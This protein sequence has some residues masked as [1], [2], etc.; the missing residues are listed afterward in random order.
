MRTSLLISAAVGLLIGGGIFFAIDGEASIAPQKKAEISVL[1]CAKPVEGL[2]EYK[3]YTCPV[4]GEEFEVL[5][6]VGDQP[7]IKTMDLRP[8][9]EFS[10]PAPL[11]ICPSNGFVIDKS[12]YSV[13]ELEVRK[14]ALSDPGY[15]K[16]LGEGLPTHIVGLEFLSRVADPKS[17]HFDVPYMALQSAWEAEACGSDYYPGIASNAARILNDE[18]RSKDTPMPTRLAYAPA[19][20]D[21]MRKAGKFEFSI[22]LADNTCH[23]LLGPAMNVLLNK[24][25]RAAKAKNIEDIVVSPDDPEL[26]EFIR[27]P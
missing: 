4:G 13:E 18:A 21:L 25:K 5:T 12:E 23:C 8:V 17:D 22:L 10:F 3:T 26:A 27:K 11:P 24:V 19:V 16:I 7:Q 9:S 20:P 2:T 1:N 6:F 15:Q 14:R